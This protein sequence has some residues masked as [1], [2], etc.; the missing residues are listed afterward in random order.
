MSIDKH[1]HD[2]T[3]QPKIMKL[4]VLFLSTSFSSIR[5]VFFSTDELLVRPLSARAGRKAGRHTRGFFGEQTNMRLVHLTTHVR[6]ALACGQIIA[7]LT[8]HGQRPVSI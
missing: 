4:Q 2:F 5:H 7:S 3:T 8:D 1:L 6:G